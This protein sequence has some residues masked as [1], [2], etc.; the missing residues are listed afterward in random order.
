MT[1]AIDTEFS[2]GDEFIGFDDLASEAGPS[3]SQSPP[4][5]PLSSSAKGKARALNDTDTDRYDYDDSS[6][7]ESKSSKKRKGKGKEVPPRKKA[8]GENGPI[9]GP[10][11]KKEEDMA[12]NRHAPWAVKVDWERCADT[13]EM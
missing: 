5:P 13:A 2:I 4:S 9:T 12:N 3:R 1:A 6:A 7:A 10:R 11:N 8:K